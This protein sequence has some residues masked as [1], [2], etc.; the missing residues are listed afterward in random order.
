[1]L[2][3]LHCLV[4]TNSSSFNA[5]LFQT[6]SAN[7]YTAIIAQETFLDSQNYTIK[8]SNPLVDVGSKDF[9]A[10]VNHLHRQA[11]E[12]KLDRLG[13]ADCIEGYTVPLQSNRGNVIVITENNK[14]R[15]ADVFDAYQAAVPVEYVRDGPE[16]YS[17]L[18]TALDLPANDQ[19]IF[20]VEHLRQES[21][22]WSINS[23]K[24]KYCLSESVKEKCKLQFHLLLI[25]VVFAICLF[26]TIVMFVVAFWVFESP[27]MTTGDAISSFM[28]RPDPYTENMCLA[29]KRFIQSHPGRWRPTAPAYFNSKPKRL[30]ESI[31]TR[32]IT[33]CLLWVH[34]ALLKDIN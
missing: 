17:W 22:T 33:L 29:S 13:N 3:S 4:T 18:C 26:K 32:V 2:L 11:L 7:A 14:N 30:Y 12:G 15:T 24:V 23:A 27:L 1:L 10:V 20:H 25:L 9:N 34:C 21:S 6:Y 28:M 31:R 5:F 19:C 8:F 16:Q